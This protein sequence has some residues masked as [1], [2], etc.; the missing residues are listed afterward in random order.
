MGLVMQQYMC[1]N[2]FGS[3]NVSHTSENKSVIFVIVW[4]IL[5]SASYMNSHVSYM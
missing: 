1:I 5:S 2:V 3:L 4:R